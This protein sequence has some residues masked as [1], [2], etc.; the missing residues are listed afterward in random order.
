MKWTASVITFKPSAREK[1]ETAKQRLAQKAAELCVCV[2]VFVCVC[3]CVCVCAEVEI[4]KE[5]D[6]RLNWACFFSV[7]AQSTSTLPTSMTGCRER[8]KVTGSN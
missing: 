8:S 1:V 5:V 4:E 2:C 3:V 7:F 6:V